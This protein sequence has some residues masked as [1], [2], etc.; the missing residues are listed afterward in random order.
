VAL[1][2]RKALVKVS[3][4]AIAF[5]D[6]ATTADGDRKRYQVTNTAKRVWDPTVAIVVERDTGGGFGVVSTG[7]TLNRLK[8][9]VIFTAAQAPGTVIRVDG[10]YLPM[11]TAAECTSYNV[12]PVASLHDTSIFGDTFTRRQQGLKTVTGEIG[13]FYVADGYFAAQ[14]SSGAPVVLEFF[15]DSSTEADL[16][17]RAIVNEQQIQA[18][19][20]GMNEQ[21]VGFVGTTDADG[22]SVSW[23]DAAPAVGDVN[24]PPNQQATIAWAWDPGLL[25]PGQTGASYV[26]PAWQLGSTT[27]AD[28]DDPVRV[29]GPPAYYAF[30]L[31]DVDKIVFGDS[32]DAVWGDSAGFTVM[33]AVEIGDEEH[34]NFCNGVAKDDGGSDRTFFMQTDN[35][36]KIVVTVFLVGGGFEQKVT[37][38]VVSKAKHVVSFTYNRGAAF[39]SRIVIYIDGTAVSMTGSTSGSDNI[40][41]LNASILR[42][43]GAT[44]PIF[45]QSFTYAWPGV[46]SAGDIA[47]NDTWIRTTGRSW[48]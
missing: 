8:G 41:N 1:A 2:G 46:H 17:V 39:G 4:T 14:L 35:T 48:A 19:I 21:T 42:L 13:G 6:E 27:G 5:T 10:S 9:T 38:A 36:G 12:T 16:R 37:S 40:V 29:A 43:G 47:A 24:L 34:L 45:R 18:V 26:G 22:R 30:T 23:D 28:A 44:N 15:S 3:G 32:L 11:S 33:Q 7:Y 25:T 20:A 31:V